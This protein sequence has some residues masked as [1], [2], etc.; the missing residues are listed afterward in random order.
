MACSKFLALE[1]A[2]AG[3]HVGDNGGPDEVAPPVLDRGSSGDQAAFAFPG[4]DVAQDGTLRALADDR[5]H[6]IRR[7]VGR[8]YLNA[9]DSGLQL[10][11]ELVVDFL[12]H[13]GARAGRALLSLI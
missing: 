11:Q 1:T 4:V 5:P 8:T 2:S 6:V 13:D 9:G 10:L 12:I 7:I 3:L